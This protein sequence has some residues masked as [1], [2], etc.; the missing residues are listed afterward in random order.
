MAIFRP[1]RRIAKP[2]MRPWGYAEAKH[3]FN[4]TSVSLYFDGSS[5][6]T[7]TTGD[8]GGILADGN[9]VFTL[10]GYIKPSSL[11]S[12]SSNHGTRNV[13]FAKASDNEN[14]SI[15]IGVSENGNLDVYIDENGDDTTKTYGNGELVVDKWHYFAVIFDNGSIR[16]HLKDNVYTG[17]FSG[18]QIDGAG[19]SPVTLGTTRHS[20]IYFD[21]YIAMFRAWDIARTEEEIE[22]YKAEELEGDETG[23]VACYPINEGEGDTI[24]DK[25]NNDIDGT[26]NG[27][28]WVE[29]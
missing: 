28:T 3:V 21:G 7:L 4:P 19:S 13:I 17:S 29:K 22:E 12:T 1:T 20:D 15:E 9:S 27:A 5:Y 25:T 16:V 11:S 18:S 10:E 24:Y 14:D 8:F 26:I 6:V 2:S 23:L